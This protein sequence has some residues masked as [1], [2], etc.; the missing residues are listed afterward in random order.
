MTSLYH[1]CVE[2]SD[3]PQQYL[4]NQQP[5]S[6]GA[7]S[8]PLQPMNYAI[9][10]KEAVPWV[11]SWQGGLTTL[12][13]S[14]YSRQDMHTNLTYDTRPLTA[15]GN[16][17]PLQGTS[18]EI[19]DHK[20]AV[21]ENILHGTSS[22]QGVICSQQASQHQSISC[23]P[24]S[25][26][27][28]DPD[29]IPDVV[30]VLENDQA[31]WAT[32]VFL[33]KDRG[34]LPPLSSTDCTIEDGGNASPR[35]MRVSTYTFPS[36]PEAARMAH[37]PLAAI[38]KP[39][40]R[41][42]FGEAPPALLVSRE[43]GP[44]CCSNCGAVICPFFEFQDCG[45]RFRCPFC[46]CIT[47]VPWQ[48]YKHLD[49]SGK[50]VDAQI[51]PELCHGSYE[52]LESPSNRQLN[53]FSGNFGTPAFIFMIDV[54]LKPIRDGTVYRICQELRSILD[55][56]PRDAGTEDSAVRVGFVTY[57]RALHLYS[58]NPSQYQPHM[59]VISDLEDLE[60][61]LVEGLLV[62]LDKCRDAINSLLDKIP[63]IFVETEESEV[64]LEPV[65]QAGLLMLKNSGCSG[66]L[67]I[68]HTTQPTGDKLIDKMDV[69]IFSAM[70]EK[71][72]FQPQDACLPLVQRSVA[73]GC[74]LDFFLFSHDMIGMATLG[75]ASLLTGGSLYMYSSLVDEGEQFQM[76]LRH[77][78]QRHIGFNGTLKVFVSKGLKVSACFGSLQSSSIPGEYK[79]ATVNAD[80]TFVVEFTHIGQVDEDRGVAIQCVL[81]YTSASGQRRTRVHNMTLNSSSHL[82]ETFRNSQAETL[83]TYFCKKAYCELL[84]TPGKTLRD[85]LV[86]ELT[87]MLACYRK[88]CSSTKVSPGQLVMPQFLKIL[89]VYLNCLRKSEVLL[90][91]GHNSVNERAYMRCWGLSMDTK[92]TARYFYPRIVQLS[93]VSE[94]KPLSAVRCSARSLSSH[95]V[96]LADNTQTLFLWVGKAAPPELA[97][98][99]F[100]MPSFNNVQ[101]GKCVLP[102]L[103]NS[104]S[105]TVRDEIERLRHQRSRDMQL[106]LVKQDEES[107]NRF[108]HLLVEDRS[109]NGGASYPDFLY[110]VHVSAMQ[111]LK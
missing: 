15:N 31:N 98:S 36:T 102:N 65:I 69:S 78:V 82:V 60:L 33:T 84:T 100:N 57:D 94:G 5:Y 42:P 106:L 64:V 51:R 50:R 72:L 54:S 35:F 68:F 37:L 92:E 4:Q 13:P 43:W 83:L 17:E 87:E 89:P 93:A 71:S 55:M 34:A 7:F 73:Q 2:M 95:G 97:Q 23:G 58:L 26:Y 75:Q 90:P 99:I 44:V 24:T 39:F 9:E 40:A 85:S 48:Y 20:Y 19:R 91:S 103:N 79:L 56:L 52:F 41:V 29:T 10:L 47:E 77:N 32:Q 101:S 86:I 67:F 70:K 25:K 81:S 28:L 53:S 74:G 21:K 8:P 46:T 45:Q 16:Y 80:N 18:P 6:H 104:I 38:I 62:H 59:L 111:L 3:L 105:Q 27:G 61:P 14:G 76:D 108:K 22:E 11:Q 66:K 1:P 107:E 12:S 109:P 30:Q 63:K 110:H 49:K 88:H 96:Y